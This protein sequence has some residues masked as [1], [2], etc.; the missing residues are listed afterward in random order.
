MTTRTSASLTLEAL[1]TALAAT[2][3]R[4]AMQ[5]G[6]IECAADDDVGSVARTLA[7]RRVHCLVVAG[8]ATAG[9]HGRLR[10]VT[11]K[12][13]LRALRREAAWRTAGDIAT[14]D[15]VTVDPGDSLLHAATLMAERRSSHVLIVSPATGRPVGILSG[16]DLARAVGELAA[17]A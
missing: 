12:D 6:F 14:G 1:R 8:P 17:V 5:L 15:A 4:R 9:G 3:V 7:E 16:L 13:V 10:V 11:D 2:P